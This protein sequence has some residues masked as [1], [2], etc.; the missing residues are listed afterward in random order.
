M[1]GCQWYR[2]FAFERRSCRPGACSTCWRR[3]TRA[4][5]RAA[6]PA[7]QRRA[8]AALRALLELLGAA[9]AAPATL[10]YAAALLLHLLQTPWRGCGV[11]CIN[12]PAGLNLGRHTTLSWLSL[13]AIMRRASISS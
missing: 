4:L 5:E 8:L 13:R 3:C 12:P 9:A 2:V 10:R 1:L 6:P 11:T 7:H